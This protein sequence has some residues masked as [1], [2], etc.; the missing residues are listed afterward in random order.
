MDVGVDGGEKEG[1]V[2]MNGA[3]IEFVLL[4]GITIYLW[5]LIYRFMSIPFIYLSMKTRK[6]SL[7]FLIMGILKPNVF[8]LFH[9]RKFTPRLL[10]SSRQDVALLSN[11][12]PQDTP[13]PSLHHVELP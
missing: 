11:C 7:V 8:C 9:F 5:T 10:V 4:F 3:G 1:Y 12:F 2:G 6:Y 13:E